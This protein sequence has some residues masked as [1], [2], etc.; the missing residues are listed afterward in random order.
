MSHSIKVVLFGASGMVGQGV[1]RECLLDPEVTSVLSIG[2]RASGKTDPKLRELVHEDFTD[3]SGIAD[4]L[5]G[6][7][8]CLFC[9]GVSSAGMD[10]ADYRRVTFDY[11]MA[12]ARV[13]AERSPNMRFL[14]I[15]GAGTDGTE[16]GSSMWARVKG[17]TENALQRLPFGRGAFMFRPAFIQPRHGEV[18]RTRWTRILYGV[19]GPLYPVWKTVFPRHVTTTE[20]LGRAMLRVAREGAGS[21]V[22][23]NADIN[24]IAAA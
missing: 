16:K 15:T 19:A 7:D 2:R 3:F 21:P 1:L 14:Y 9:L 22:L 13:L 17:E 23:E 11:T 4:Q 24:A 8:A 6:W 10:E 12:A 5:A 18:S 20:H